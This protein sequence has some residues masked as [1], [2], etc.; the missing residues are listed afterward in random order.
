VELAGASVSSLRTNCKTAPCCS[1]VAV[2]PLLV[3]ETASSTAFFW[4]KMRSE[5]KIYDKSEEVVALT[6]NNRNSRNC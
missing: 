4:K 1:G 5:R 2:F 6:H 3:N